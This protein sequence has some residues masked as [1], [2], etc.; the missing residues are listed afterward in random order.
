[1]AKPSIY[2][3]SVV[4]SAEA[5]AAAPLTFTY[6]IS[7][8]VSITTTVSGDARQY[9]SVSIMNG[10]A[11]LWTTTLTQFAPTAQIPYDIIA[12][13][14]TIKANGTFTLTIPTN[15]APGN[16]VANLVIASPTNP[17]GQPFQAT[18]AMWN[19]TG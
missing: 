10:S 13:Q 2:D 1:M 16:V 8:L 12:G 6:P 7:A 14:L 17:T 15:L 4:F 19:L 9:A 11:M 3:T 18:V 5:A